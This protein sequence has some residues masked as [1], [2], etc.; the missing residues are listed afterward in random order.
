MFEAIETYLHWLWTPIVAI[1]LGA[2]YVESGKLLKHL[3]G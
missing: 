3:L 1:V 2:V